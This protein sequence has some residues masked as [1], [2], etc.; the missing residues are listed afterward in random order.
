MLPPSPGENVEAVVYGMP[1][2]VI[3]DTGGKFH[4]MSDM[5]SHAEISISEGFIEGGRIECW[6]H[7]ATFDLATGRALTLPATDPV[8]VFDVEVS[9]GYVVVGIDL[10]DRARA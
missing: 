6:A 3:M 8:R 4:A 9:D 7:G 10:A 2:L 5:C 1:V